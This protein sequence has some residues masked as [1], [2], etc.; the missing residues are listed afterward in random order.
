MSRPEDIVIA[1]EVNSEGT[2]SVRLNLLHDSVLFE[3]RNEPPEAEA[4]KTML[5]G[6]A[7]I[8]HVRLMNFAECYNDALVVVHA[9]TDYHT[10]Q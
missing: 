9:D 1:I 3:C 4:V 6:L 2:N 8:I 10:L 7:K 5:E